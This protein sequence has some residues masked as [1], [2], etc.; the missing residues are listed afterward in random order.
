MPPAYPDVW[1]KLPVLQLNDFLEI[2]LVILDKSLNVSE[3]QLLYLKKKITLSI[4]VST[5][6][7]NRVMPLS[8][9]PSSPPSPPWY[10]QEEQ[11]DK[12][13]DTQC[14]DDS[15]PPHSNH[16]WEIVFSVSLMMEILNQK[17]PEQIINQTPTKIR[18][19]TLTTDHLM[20][21][22]AIG[23][24][25]CLWKGYFIWALS[26]NMLWSSGKVDFLFCNILSTK[27]CS[28]L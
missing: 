8:Q 12:I 9:S 16:S 24:H 10:R 19:P 13:T 23:N 2:I 26:Y 1:K 15:Y 18:V 28:N 20:R 11:A 4:V 6:K 21:K 22:I 5:L 25:N 14:S 17:E 27:H 7:E 3:A